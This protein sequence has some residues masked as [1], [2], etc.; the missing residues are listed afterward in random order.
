MVTPVT[1]SPVAF[2]FVH[3]RRVAS[4]L[5]LPVQPRERAVRQ[6]RVDIS[7][8]DDSKRQR[9][10]EPVGEQPRL[11]GETGLP[12]GAPQELRQRPG[13]RSSLCVNAT[14]RCDCT[15]RHI[16]WLRPYAKGAPS[17]TYQTGLM[18]SAM[19]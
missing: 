7:R 9:A 5:T 15:N 16:F 11:R 3:T 13:A 14:K 2:G 19:L 4:S 8:L 10:E 1:G 6:D 17:Y 18:A 12:P